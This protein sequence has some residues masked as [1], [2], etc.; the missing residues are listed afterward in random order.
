MQSVLRGP[1]CV[2]FDRNRHFP[3]LALTDEVLEEAKCYKS[4]SLDARPAG[5]SRLT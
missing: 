5:K 4:E 1:G 3:R 2:C